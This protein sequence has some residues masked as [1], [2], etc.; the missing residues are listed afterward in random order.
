M[1]KVDAPATGLFARIW[2]RI[3]GEVVGDVPAEDALCE[4]DCRKNQ[5]MKDE[6]ATCER[7]LSRAAG[8]LMPDKRGDRA[9]REAL[10]RS[11]GARGDRVASGA[12]NRPNAKRPG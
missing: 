9:S 6:W 11:R 3:K 10:T 5:C 1:Q 12:S 4:F 2:R 7:R 8:E